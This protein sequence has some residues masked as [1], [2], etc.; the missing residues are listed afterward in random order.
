MQYVINEAPINKSHVGWYTIQH[1]NGEITLMEILRCT[2]RH[3]ETDMAT[4][5]T[6]EE[7][8]RC[9][10]RC[11][12]PKAAPLMLMHHAQQNLK[13]QFPTTRSG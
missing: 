8:Q 1:E 2:Y 3:P 7:E 9:T 12:D 13:N 10:L 6:I 11:T 4:V 5:R